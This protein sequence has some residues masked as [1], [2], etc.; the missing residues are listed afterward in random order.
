MYKG[1]FSQTLIQHSSQFRTKIYTE[2]VYM[3]LDERHKEGGWCRGITGT[4]TFI[5][6]QTALRTVYRLAYVCVQFGFKNPS[7]AAC[8]SHI[9][10]ALQ[11]WI[12]TPLAE[13][14]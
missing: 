5:Y 10:C 13:P 8:D 9:Q 3:E 6:I 2:L 11:R 14:C 7:P 4:Y 1:I 12:T